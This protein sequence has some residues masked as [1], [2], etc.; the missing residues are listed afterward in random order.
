MLVERTYLTQ[1]QPPHGTLVG[2]AKRPGR[3]HPGARNRDGCRGSVVRVR[4][5]EHRGR[6]GSGETTELLCALVRLQV[7][8]ARWVREG[9]F[10]FS[11]SLETEGLS[12]EK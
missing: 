8:V 7:G 4:V 3:S 9:L 1:F 5:L 10:P 11:R 6:L 12:R 2:G